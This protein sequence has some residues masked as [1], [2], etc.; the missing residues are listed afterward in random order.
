[1]KLPN[2]AVLS[3]TAIVRS[4][5]AGGLLQG[6]C[7]TIEFRADAAHPQGVRGVD[8]AT[9]DR[10]ISLKETHRISVQ[11]AVAKSA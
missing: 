1:M 3:R 7:R 4:H 5:H 6:N 11:L 2:A 9:A 10:L 8:Y